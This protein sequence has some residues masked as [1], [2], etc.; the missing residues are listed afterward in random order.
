[1]ELPRIIHPSVYEAPLLCAGLQTEVKP[2]GGRTTQVS[3][4]P[5]EEIILGLQGEVCWA[6]HGLSTGVGGCP[7]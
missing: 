7:R 1:M 5:G 3:R 2:A 4:A 6:H